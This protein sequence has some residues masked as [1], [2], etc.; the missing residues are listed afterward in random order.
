MKAH[1]YEDR[2]LE[3]IAAEARGPN[4]LDLGYAQMPNGYL[5]KRAELRITGLDLSPPP[6]DSGYT[7]TL[8]GDIG[9]LGKLFG[10]RRF[11]TIV[12]GEFIEHLEQPYDFLRSLH[13]HLAERGLLVLSTPNPLGFPVLL[14][15]LFRDRRHF[16]TEDHTYYFLPRWVERM[17]D[18]T[19]YRLVRTR[20]VGLWIPGIR[21][22]WAPVALSYQV[23]YV[24]TPV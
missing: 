8:Q 23:I 16:Y 10:A 20:P 5:A 22:P 18:R 24:A 7:E 21:I 3:M 19:G 17:L 12:A 4:V 14:S 11:D 15:E 1:W 13:G 9:E 2:R 6:A